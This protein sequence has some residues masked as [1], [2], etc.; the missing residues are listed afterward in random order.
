MI[1]VRLFAWPVGHDGKHVPKLCPG[2]KRE[3]SVDQFGIRR[4]VGKPRSRC[5]ECDANDIR[6]Y[7]D[8]DRDRARKIDREWRENNPEK[9]A[10]AKRRWAISHPEQVKRYNS[11]ETHK[12]CVKR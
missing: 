4:K 8:Q 11:S 9:V 10:A 1:D 5:K 12:K 3:K 2:C 6:S 7:R